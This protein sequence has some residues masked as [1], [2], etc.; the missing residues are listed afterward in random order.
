[1]KRAAI[2]LAALALTACGSESDT[3]GGEEF[4]TL[5]D[6]DTIREPFGPADNGGLY[7]YEE[8][9]L[10]PTSVGEVITVTQ[11]RPFQYVD[12]LEPQSSDECRSYE[13][14]GDG[15]PVEILCMWTSFEPADP[16]DLANQ[17]VGFRETY[18]AVQ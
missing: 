12:G 5:V 4:G 16:P 7:R 17:E 18:V 2:L 13:K 3:K 14:I 6:C 1:M 11:C 15:S 9:E 8:W 10:V